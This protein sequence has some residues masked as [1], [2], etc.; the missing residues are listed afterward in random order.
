MVM[1]D[2]FADPANSVLINQNETIH[3]RPNLAHEPLNEGVCQRSF[4]R[5]ENGFDFVVLQD[6]L[7]RLESAVAIVDEVFAG[8]FGMILK[9]HIETLKLSPPPPLLTPVA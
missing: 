4:G 1:G 7:E 9:V 8:V 6:M 3:N 2:C 5:G